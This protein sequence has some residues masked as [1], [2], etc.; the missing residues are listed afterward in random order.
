MNLKPSI[1]V[2]MADRRFPGS[3]ELHITVKTDLK[4]FWVALGCTD[5]NKEPIGFARFEYIERAD[6]IILGE[7]LGTFEL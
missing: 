2:L 3:T 6:E 1:L 4:K 7:S 5:L